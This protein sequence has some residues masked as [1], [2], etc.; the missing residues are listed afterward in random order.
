MDNSADKR[1]TE[2]VILKE[3]KREQ[4]VE[5]F[6]G[7]CNCAQAVFSTY[8]DLFGIDRRTAMNLTNSMGGGISRLR[9]VC[10]TVSAMALLAG[11]AE[12]DVDPGD[13]KA[14][15]K[16]Y[17]RTRDLTA[18]FEEENGSLIC[19]ELL[20]ILGREQA[21][22]PSERTP[23]YYKKRPCAKFVACAA[24]IIEEELFDRD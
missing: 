9:E 12:G 10:G 7:G 18:K 2:R 14:R 24:G 21:A 4:A 20:G 17:Q 23:E 11:L 22:R 5:A 19:R 16:V 8:A 6:L 3:S 13:L 1:Q 15:E